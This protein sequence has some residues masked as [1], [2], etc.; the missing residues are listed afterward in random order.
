ME[1][2]N[3]KKSFDVLNAVYTTL[4]VT[5]F[6][7]ML[8]AA[9]TMDYNDAATAENQNLGYEKNVITNK[10]PLK[11]LWLGSAVLAAGAAGIWSRKKQNEKSR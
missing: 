7:L 9:G 6:L 1:N 5:G 11:A 2:T 4:A 3:K 10:N 8:G